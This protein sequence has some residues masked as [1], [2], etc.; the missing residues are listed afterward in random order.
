MPIFREKEGEQGTFGPSMSAAMS[1][2]RQA[3]AKADKEDED[4]KKMNSLKKAKSSV[5]K[6]KH[7]IKDAM[8]EHEGHEEEDEMS[9]PGLSSIGEEEED[10]E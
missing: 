6:A 9:G 2:H 4:E 8:E 7:D 3:K 10:E 5:K 1:L